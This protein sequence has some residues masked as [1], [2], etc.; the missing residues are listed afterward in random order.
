MIA[1]ALRFHSGRF[2]ATPW[3]RHVNE[4]AP[5]WPPSPWRLLRALVATWKRKLDGEFV[6]SDMLAL[7]TKLA[8]P[9]SFV[10][11]PATTGHSRHYMPWFKKGPDDKTLVF[12]AFVAL[13]KTADIVVAWPDE[14]LTAEQRGIV[15]QLVEH[16]GFFGR[17][18]SWCDGRVLDDQTAESLCNS[19]K[20]SNGGGPHWCGPLGKRPVTR[21]EEV[22]RVLCPD[23]QAAFLDEH[24][25]RLETVTSGR[26]RNKQ[27]S[28]TRH[29]LYEPNWHLCAETALLH[30]E[31][32][33]DP[34]GSCW[35]QYVRRSDCFRVAPRHRPSNI[36]TSRPRRVITVARYA[37]DGAVLPLI[38]ETLPVAESARITL[39]G[40]FKRLKLDQ[41]YGG[42]APRP[43]PNDA[44][45]FRSD[46]FSGKDADGTPL[47]NH[48]HA[49]Y[50]PT[51]ED[52]D[53]RLDHLTIVAE[54]GFG[55]YDPLEVRTLDQFRRLRW[56]DGEPLNL[57]L[58]GLGTNSDFRATI[59]NESR[60][61]VS[62]T[63]FLVTRHPK[64]NGSKRDPTELLGSN[65]QP[66]FVAAVL[67][68]EL[69]RLS[70]RRIQ[71]GHSPLP[72]IVAIEPLL[73]GDQIPR[74]DPRR[75][76]GP[77]STGAAVRPIQFK[78]FRRKRSDDGGVRPNGAWRIMFQKSVQ[79][80]ICLGHSAHFGLGL[81]APEVG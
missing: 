36:T 69:D 3:G 14:E 68:E 7:L 59:L 22:V 50:L 58:V 12:D 54:M 37:L 76:H 1:I 65:N 20:R 25:V 13:N 48:R 52:G 67:S 40:I 33:S 34:P 38:T 60:V 70:Q 46:V 77:Y 61:W 79:G 44:P 57:L 27:S 30:D 49:Y 74:I 39:M 32:W 31:K 5:E 55:V 24:V 81:F 29:A 42:R 21:D 15:S 43:I 73:D 64:K 71:I 47:T 62:V 35:V 11:P 4:G 78:R 28:T 66:A 17:S 18:E 23:P 19:A 75:W 80:P 10:L 2:H 56:G 6:E 45:R 41:H 51:D 8:S 53:G 26:G 16:L 72:D 9:P 63:P